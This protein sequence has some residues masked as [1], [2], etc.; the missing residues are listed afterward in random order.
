[1][2]S[3]ANF[4]TLVAHDNQVSV[5]DSKSTILH[6]EL[7]LYGRQSIDQHFIIANVPV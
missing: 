6:I 7:E 2:S 4:S 3:T 1:M 5:G